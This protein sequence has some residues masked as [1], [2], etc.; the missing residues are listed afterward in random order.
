[1]AQPT[2]PCYADPQR[3][4][5]TC[6]TYGLSSWELR[7]EARRLLFERG[8]QLWEVAARL[9]LPRPGRGRS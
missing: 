5:L 8:W 6:G 1:M 3:K 9:A 2:M 7:A 4:P